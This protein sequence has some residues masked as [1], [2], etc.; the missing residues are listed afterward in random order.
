MSSYDIVA[1]TGGTKEWAKELAGVK[2]TFTT[3]MRGNGF[4][5]DEEDIQLSYEEIWN[6][7]VAM[8][9]EIAVVHELPTN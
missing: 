2:Y 9:D 6:G 8:A 1:T 5:T 4:V 3:E 7:L